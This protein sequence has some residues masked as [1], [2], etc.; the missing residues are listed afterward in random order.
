MFEMIATIGEQFN[1]NWQEVLRHRWF[2]AALVVVIFF[3]LRKYVVSKLFRM[4][5]NKIRTRYER[6]GATNVRIELIQNIFDSVTFSMRNIFFVIGLHIAVFVAQFP[7]RIEVLTFHVLNSIVLFFIGFA[8]Y[9]SFDAMKNN[10]ILVHQFFEEKFDK[11]LIDFSLKVFQ[12]LAVI[13][14]VFL[15]LQEWGFEVSTFVA[16]LGLGGL[17]F[18]LAAKDLV[19]NIFAGFVVITDKPYSIGDWIETT[20]T[21]GTVVEITFR[22]TKVRTF[23]NAIVTVPN[24]SLIDGAV[25][26]WSRMEKRRV[27]F[28]LGVTYSTTVEQMKNV[29]KEIEVMLRVHPDVHQDL[30]FVKFN[31]FN[32][33]SLDIFLYYFTTSTVWGEYLSVREDTFLKI[34]DILEANNVSVAFPSRSIYMENALTLSQPSA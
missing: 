18:A 26:N 4:I 24:A 22:S 11:I 1:Y 5:S 13:T 34:M 19:A 23:A 33:S 3:V 2:Y 16:G 30:I 7:E 29:V 25:T 6:E 10:M 20:Q 31:D 9:K 8:I 17:A 27:S 28:K 15:I 12:A 32:D 21:E 14:T